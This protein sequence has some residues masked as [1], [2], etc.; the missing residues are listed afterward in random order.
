M[1]YEGGNESFFRDLIPLLLMSNIVLALFNL[2]PAF[3]MD[4]GRVLRALLSLKWSRYQATRIAARIGQIIAT[5]GFMYA[6]FTRP[7]D[8]MPG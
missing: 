4:G 6:C 2:I 5:L 3:P 7:M 8:V 1:N